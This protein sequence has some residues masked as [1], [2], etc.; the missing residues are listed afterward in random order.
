MVRFDITKAYHFIEIFKHQTDYLVFSWPDKIDNIKYYYFLDL[1]FGL[2]SAC[3]IYTKLCM[4][5]ASKW[6][7]KENQ[8]TMF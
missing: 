7:G 3:Y 2:S 8:A 1:P 5:L 4:S 6:Q